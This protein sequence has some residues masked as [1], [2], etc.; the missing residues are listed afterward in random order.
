MATTN[1]RTHFA[2]SKEDIRELDN[3]AEFFGETHS[4]VIRRSLILLNYLTFSKV[5]IAG[6]WKVLEKKAAKI[7]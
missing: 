5:D 3:L 6:F 2:L 4:A 1:K 7:S